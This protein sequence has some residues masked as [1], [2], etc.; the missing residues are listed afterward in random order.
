VELSEFESLLLRAMIAADAERATL[1]E[2]LAT[3]SVRS[4]EYSGVGL[5]TELSVA[6]EA[7]RLK[8]TS[9]YIQDVPKLHLVHPSLVDDAGAILWIAEGAISMLECYTYEGA[10]PEAEGEFRIVTE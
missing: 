3:A 6:A 10:W 5:F 8:M 7:P 1:G 9:R 2:Q 4:R